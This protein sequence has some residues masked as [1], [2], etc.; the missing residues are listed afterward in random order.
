[1]LSINNSL[2]HEKSCGFC[3]ARHLKE[4]KQCLSGKFKIKKSSKYFKKHFCDLFRF[5]HATPPVLGEAGI[6]RR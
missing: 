6:N 3:A 4:L 5:L 1:M 2:K